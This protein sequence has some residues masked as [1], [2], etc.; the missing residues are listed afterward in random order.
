MNGSGV[1]EHMEAT[2]RDKV[3]ALFFPLSG[4]TGLHVLATEVAFD[5]W[6]VTV[7]P[8]TS[9]TLMYGW[10]ASTEIPDQSGQ[11]LKCFM[12]Q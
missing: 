8:N 3:S 2:Y 12:R 9:I 7:T 4:F 11:A 6:I 10:L 5:G 1:N